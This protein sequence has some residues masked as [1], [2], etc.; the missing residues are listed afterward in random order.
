MKDIEFNCTEQ[1][2]SV[3]AEFW[4]GLTFEDVQRVLEEW[5]RCLEW[6]IANGGEYFIK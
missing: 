4:D 5:I 3:I 2:M 6:I 1:I